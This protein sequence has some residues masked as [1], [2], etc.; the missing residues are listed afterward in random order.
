[1]YGRETRQV[2]KERKKSCIYIAAG[3]AATNMV[4]SERTRA[5]VCKPARRA[6][7]ILYMLTYSA[8]ETQM[9]EQWRIFASFGFVDELGFSFRRYC[10]AY[11][12]CMSDVLGMRCR[13]IESLNVKL[14]RG[15]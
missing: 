7:C 1:M 4:K 6:V 3:L 10:C 12:K 11:G 5:S 14:S 15:N 8:R 9:N 2:E 13:L